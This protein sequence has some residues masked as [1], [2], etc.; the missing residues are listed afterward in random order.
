MERINEKSDHGVNASQNP[1]KWWL[2]EG[3]CEQ[4]LEVL[5]FLKVSKPQAS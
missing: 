3:H 1:S 5:K 4:K 2:L